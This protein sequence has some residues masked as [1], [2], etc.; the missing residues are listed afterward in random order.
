M[1]VSIINFGCEKYVNIVIHKHIFYKIRMKKINC[2]LHRLAQFAGLLCKSRSKIP[3]YCIYM[4]MSHLMVEGLQYLGLSQRWRRQLIYR[5][6][7]AVIRGLG[8]SSFIRRTAPLSD[9]EYKLGVLRTYSNL[10]F[11]RLF[12]CPVHGNIRQIS[13]SVQW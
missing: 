6:T 3:R 9:L 8:F 10:V 5:A 7:R 4:E 2:L 13:C 1:H 12:S 11:R